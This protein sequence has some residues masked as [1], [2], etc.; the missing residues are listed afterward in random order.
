MKQ[1]KRQ[2]GKRENE[3]R[4]AFDLFYTEKVLREKAK[5]WLI[6]RKETETKKA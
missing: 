5:R 1:S 4:E 6:V 2:R 3:M